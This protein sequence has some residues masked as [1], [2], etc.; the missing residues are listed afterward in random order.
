MLQ[1]FERLKSDSRIRLRFAGTIESVTIDKH[2]LGKLE[3]RPDADIY[4]V[5]DD[6]TGLDAM[7]VGIIFFLRFCL[8]DIWSSTIFLQLVD[9]IALVAPRG[10]FAFP[11]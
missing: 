10:Y 5:I 4:V 3:H 7:T 11:S 9:P 8:L 6:D 2:L 1:S